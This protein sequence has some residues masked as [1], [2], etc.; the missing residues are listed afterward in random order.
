MKKNSLSLIISVTILLAI[1]IYVFK[2]EPMAI[3]I[4]GIILLLSSYIIVIVKHSVSWYLF[5]IDE[6]YTILALSVIQGTIPNSLVLAILITASI[7]IY[8]SLN[9]SFNMRVLALSSVMLVTSIILTYILYSLLRGFIIMYIEII[10][11]N[12][13]YFTLVLASSI[14]IFILFLINLL[15]KELAHKVHLRK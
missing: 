15:I 4:I 9:G 12:I 5:F 13:I 2:R 10:N 11:A 3:G 1:N 14:S 6:A 7:I 8:L